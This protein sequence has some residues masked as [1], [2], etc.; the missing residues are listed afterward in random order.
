MG[1]ERI[2]TTDR[3]LRA[4]EVDECTIKDVLDTLL[5]GTS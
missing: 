1:H 4:I 3:Y 5:A 2:G